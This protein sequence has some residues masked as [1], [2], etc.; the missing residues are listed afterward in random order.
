MTTAM[1]SR[2]ADHLYWMSRY[3]ER[4]EHAARL[5]DV[6]LNLMLEDAPA[7]ASERSRRL[8]AAMDVRVAEDPHRVTPDRVVP[9]MTFDLTNPS[10]IYSG[11]CAARENAR[12]VRDMISSEMWQHANRLYLDLR[13]AGSHGRWQTAPHA[14][15]Q[16]VKE[17]VQL[18][19]GV[20]DA[21]MNH[22]T[23]WRFIQL[24]LYLE[25]AQNVAILL[26]TSFHGE[27]SLLQPDSPNAY[28]EWVG[29]LK[30]A[31]AHEPFCKVHSADLEPMAIADFLLL[32]P[33]FPH[34]V[35]FSVDRV[36]EALQAVGEGS[37]GVDHSRI[38]RLAGR[39]T[40][41]LRYL[42]MEEIQQQGELH[43][44]LESIRRQLNDIHVWLYQAYIAYPIESALR[45]GRTA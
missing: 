9:L 35:R 4:A 3:L 30:C 6:H 28:L 41:Q 1:L 14:L 17:G 11:I 7:L 38:D 43:G 33:E 22:G 12:Q 31:T 37:P 23:G 26:D 32:D 25:R 19:R 8:L 29:L 42:S 34:S 18:F 13:E 45:R 5:L 39:L 10:S 24:G 2:V 27:H 44:F 36:A 40:S 16:A 15:F 20:T 21:T